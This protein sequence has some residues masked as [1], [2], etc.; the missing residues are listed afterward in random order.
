MAHSHTVIQLVG[1]D[2]LAT[3]QAVGLGNAIPN[4]LPKEAH[5]CDL[6]HCINAAM[7]EQ[8]G[9]V[10]PRTVLAL[11]G[12]STQ[13][14]ASAALNSTGSRRTEARTGRDPQDVPAA[15]LT[16]CHFLFADTWTFPPHQYGPL[17]G[18]ARGP[19]NG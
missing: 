12:Q 7:I 10:L 11:G 9:S 8:N 1:N 3:Q 14:C 17:L 19:P 18:V 6:Y 13:R 15:V 5:A 2:A 16:G 4:N